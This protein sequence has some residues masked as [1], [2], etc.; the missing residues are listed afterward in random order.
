MAGT[1]RAATAIGTAAL[2][3]AVVA[4]A[5]IVGLDGFV[6]RY[7]ATL[8]DGGTVWAQGIDLLNRAAFREVAAFA[9]GAVLMLAGGLLMILRSSRAVGFPLFYVG[10]VHFLTT[11][12]ATLAAPLLGR[13]RPIEAAG[14]DLWFTGG[15]SFPSPDAAFFAGLFFPLI[16]LF[17]RWSP[18]LV[19]PPL[20][21]A[22][23]RLMEHDHYL[24]DVSASLA[25]AALLAAALAALAEKGRG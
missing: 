24:S 2:F 19:L 15:D 14:G 18:L 7:T 1:S 21:I 4:A 3:F 5:G 10:L 20:F 8:Q 11:G 23:A 25:L 13:V 22:A 17:P 16:V 12:A 9:L 6:A